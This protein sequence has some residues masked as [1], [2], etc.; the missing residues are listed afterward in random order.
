[1][2]LRDKIL[3]PSTLGRLIAYDIKN[4]NLYPVVL[5][6]A[7]ENRIGTT[8]SSDRRF[9]AWTSKNS[10]FLAHDE[11]Q[12]TMWNQVNVGEACVSRPVATPKGFL[13]CSNY[14]S[15]VH[16]STERTNS[17]LWRTNLA[18]Q[19][20]RPPVVGN[21]DVFVLS[22]DG[23]CEALD[24]ETGNALWP[25]TAKRVNRILGVGKEHLYIR[26]TSG[27]LAS[28]RL[29][30]GKMDG[31][32][33]ALLQQVVPNSINDRLFVVTR[34]GR[35]TC[36]REEAAVQ[37]TMYVEF[38]P[39]GKKSSSEAQPSPSEPRRTEPS[40]TDD[41]FGSDPVQSAP[42]R[43]DSTDPFDPFGGG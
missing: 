14:G 26:D 20:T 21:K 33:S 25:Q 28:L 17:I 27:M 39:G 42:A 36:L 23:Q 40:A 4:P 32:T 8:L 22:D 9:I 2:P 18:M 11:D 24:L 13:F 15:V 5:R 19:T 12:P 6:A 41:P 3:V 10:L 7:S 31:R 35:I 38:K 37:P 43:G 34:D 30:D 29:S 1:M 16:V